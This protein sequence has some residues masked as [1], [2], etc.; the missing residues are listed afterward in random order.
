MLHHKN[1]ESLSRRR[2]G[3]SSS[4]WFVSSAAKG[5][6]DKKDRPVTIGS[7]N[8]VFL[9]ELNKSYFGGGVGIEARPWSRSNCE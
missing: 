9:G 2:G 4:D 8:M 5:I 6:T 1:P 7:G 3:S